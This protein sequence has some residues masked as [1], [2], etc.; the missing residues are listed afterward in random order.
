[1]GL[2]NREAGDRSVVLWAQTYTIRLITE[3]GT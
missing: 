1:M 2:N 3:T